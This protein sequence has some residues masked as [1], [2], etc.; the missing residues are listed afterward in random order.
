MF[1]E[2]T[3]TVHVP[4][5]TDNEIVF[6]FAPLSLKFKI[7]K[8]DFEHAKPRFEE[9]QILAGIEKIQRACNNFS[10]MKTYRFA[11]FFSLGVT[12]FFT[13]IALLFVNKG[14]RHSSE[15]DSDIALL[16]LINRWFMA[17]FGLEII[18]F[19]QN[20]LVTIILACKARRMRQIY[21]EKVYK[22][23]TE[24]NEELK[25]SDIRWKLG[26]C[27]RWIEISLDYK[28]KDLMMHQR[29]DASL[30]NVLEA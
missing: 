29:K 21:E 9:P 23:T 28:K 14:T 22:V 13:L 27:L 1:L 24:M 20:T 18:A 3:G 12:C 6:P 25:S 4:K 16:K 10:E 26:K 15:E 17:A 8:K 5:T 2:C 19:F 11:F 7:N 30:I